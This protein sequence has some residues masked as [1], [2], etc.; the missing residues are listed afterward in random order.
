[1]LQNTKVANPSRGGPHLAVEKLLPRYSF[2][3]DTF[4]G[5]RLQ[6][7]NIYLKLLSL[8]LDSLDPGCTQ[9]EL[10][11]QKLYT[12]SWMIY[13]SSQ[14]QIIQGFDILYLSFFLLESLLQ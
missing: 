10:I 4:K 12:D 6:K 9:S 13:F 11:F 2:S 8:V 14:D 3:S 5:I 7:L 1:M